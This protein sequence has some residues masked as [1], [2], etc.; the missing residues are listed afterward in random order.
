LL[1]QLLSP[2]GCA[3][4]IFLL[5]LW[6]KYLHFLYI[7]LSPLQTS[8]EIPDH[9]K[10]KSYFLYMCSPTS[11]QRLPWLLLCLSMSVSLFIPLSFSLLLSLSL[12]LLLQTRVCLM[13]TVVSGTF[14]IAI[15]QNK[16][17]FIYVQWKWMHTAYIL[18]QSFKNAYIRYKKRDIYIFMWQV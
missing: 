14:C 11:V 17:I 12:S 8:W 18:E 16:Y 5:Y 15:E 3:S 2:R 10:K 6:G 9:L 4:F 1:F 13:T 7:S